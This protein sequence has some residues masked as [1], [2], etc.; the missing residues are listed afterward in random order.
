MIEMWFLATAAGF[1]FS[2]F[3]YEL[4][5]IIYNLVFHPLA[6]FPGPW[7]AG[8]SDFAEMYYNVI[9]GGVYFK[10]IEKM[11]ERYGPI[12]RINRDELSIIDPDF[13]EQRFGAIGVR[14]NRSEKTQRQFVSPTSIL[15]TID[16]DH[17]R[18]RRQPLNSFFSKQAIMRIESII[19]S[20][21]DKVIEK[22]KGAYAQGTLL[23]TQDV[24]GALTTDVISHY[25]Y[26]ESFGFLDHP[27]FKNDYL[28]DVSGFFFAQHIARHFPLLISAMQLIPER[29]LLMLSK[30]MA[31]MNEIMVSSKK[32]AQ[33]T[34]ASVQNGEKQA[35]AS[36][37]PRS[38]FHT[39][40]NAH[41]L[42][43][44]ERSL[45][46]LTDEGIVIM[47]AGLETTARFLTNITVHLLSNRDMLEKLQAELRSVMETP[48]ARVPWTTLESLPYLSAVVSEGLR[49]ENF[50]TTR[51]PRVILEPLKFNEWT[52]PAGATLSASPTL[53]N[54]NPA[55]FPDPHIFRPERWIEARSRGKNL[56]KYLAS[57]ARGSRM[58]L[59][60]NLAYAELYLMLAAL[61]RNFDFELVDSSVK[62]VIAER[63]FGLGY[64][65][66]YRFGVKVRVTKI[67][68]G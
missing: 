58:C 36:G 38:L 52:I 55:I 3:M 31:S 24:F 8:A 6:K 45:E 40:A 46:R 28:R 64:T 39:L 1:V 44:T 49:C 35:G 48:D 66:D 54:N 63:E 13:Q 60:V 9:R 20:K 43:P 23:E 59:G 50:M 4:C 30:G 17:H 12:V 26:G 56:Q 68:E 47:V 15:N 32:F 21:V 57:F 18:I 42:P 67:F 10:E 2:W 16:H 65:K 37:I 53:I 27:G 29:V 22:L 25:S 51:T 14:R 41:N 11:H 62:D 19:Q 5:H 61:Y 7:W 34:L 33:R